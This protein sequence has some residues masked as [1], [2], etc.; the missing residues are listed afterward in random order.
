MRSG[1]PSGLETNPAT[2][3]PEILELQ[4][5]GKIMRP[6]G[7]NHRLQI[8]TVLAVHAHFLALNLSGDLDF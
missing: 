3:V 1:V 2:S 5:D 4:R 6:D 8:I 7:R